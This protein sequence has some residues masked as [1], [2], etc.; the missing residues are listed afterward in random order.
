MFGKKKEEADSDRIDQ[1]EQEVSILKRVLGI[2]A[3]GLDDISQASVEQSISIE[4]LVKTSQIQ[5]KAIKH[6]L[7]TTDESNMLLKQMAQHQLA[8]GRDDTK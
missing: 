2:F 8:N 1:L 5:T 6:V 4:E 7:E 3:K